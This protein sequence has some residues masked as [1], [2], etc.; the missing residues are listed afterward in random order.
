MRARDATTLCFSARFC[1]SGGFAMNAAVGGAAHVVAVDSSQPAVE[2]ARRNAARNGLGDRVVFVREDA[3]DYMKARP[4]PGPQ[5]P[6][7][8]LLC[9]IAGDITQGS[10]TSCLRTA[11]V[12]FPPRAFGC[13]FARVRGYSEETRLRPARPE[14]SLMSYGEGPVCCIGL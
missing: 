12:A 4:P 14:T 2:A 11:A 1:Y 6:P 9:R 7:S 13:V 10:F 8:T 3:L 5:A